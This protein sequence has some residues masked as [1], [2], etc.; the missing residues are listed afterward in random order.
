[1]P[2]HMR[3]GRYIKNLKHVSKSKENKIYKNLTDPNS[4][5]QQ[6]KQQQ[7]QQKK[8]EEEDGKKE[9]DE[10]EEKEKEQEEKIEI[11]KSGELA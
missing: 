6:Q 1:M 3:T 7:Q 4:A 5:R 10:D 9:K 2:E 8:D 11:V